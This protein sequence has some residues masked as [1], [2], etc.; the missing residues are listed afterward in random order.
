MPQGN[1]SLGAILGS[2]SCWLPWSTPLK[3]AE[4]PLLKEP[5][6]D[7]RPII[8]ILGCA[9]SESTLLLQLLAE[10]GAF[11]YPTNFLSRFYATLVLLSNGT[12]R[13][14]DCRPSD[15]ICLAVQTQ[16]QIYVSKQVL[17]IVAPS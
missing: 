6:P 7:R 4:T 10:S 1:R 11:A 2:K 3:V 16:A 12:Q 13:L 5:S 9:R 14:V 8:L 17:D 15:A